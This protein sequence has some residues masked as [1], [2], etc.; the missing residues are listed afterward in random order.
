MHLAGDG[1]GTHFMTQI[2]LLFKG[3]EF[4][5]GESTMTEEFRAH[6]R[7]QSKMAVLCPPAEAP[8]A[9]A[10]GTGIVDCFYAL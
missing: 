5:F 2:G 10:S 4:L 7:H 3:E 6:Q 9:S 1:P 8:P